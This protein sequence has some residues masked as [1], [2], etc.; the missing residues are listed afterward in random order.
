MNKYIDV[1]EKIDSPSALT[2][3]MGDIIYKEIFNSIQNKIIIHVDFANVESIIT[4]FLNNAIG[5]LYKD[6]TSEEIKEYLVL[7]NFPSAKIAALNVVITNA[8]K[9]YQNKAAYEKAVKEVINVE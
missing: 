8:K 4:P 9:Y 2:Q 3:D 1:A 5:Q 6:F 7:D